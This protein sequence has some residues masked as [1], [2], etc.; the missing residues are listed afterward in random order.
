MMP[1][2]CLMS[3]RRRHWQRSKT[4]QSIDGLDKYSELFLVFTRLFLTVL[5]AVLFGTSIQASEAD[6][7][8]ALQEGAIVLFRHANAPG[9][10]DPPG[11]RLGDCTTQRNLDAVGREQARR[12]G[13]TFRQKRIKIGEVLT[14]QWCRTEET[15]R[16]AF[17][18]TAKGE[19]IFNSF[20]DDRTNGPLQT[21]AATEL[22]SQWKW[23]G[24]LVVV[25]HQVNITALTDVFPASGEGVV[26]RIIN[27]QVRV[28]G[29]IKP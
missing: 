10:G 24:S 4:D 5:L 9:G 14:S 15:A 18:D 17:G 25:T 21:K 29:R 28:V 23:S 13:E 11:L 27:G 3:I 2:F 22:L 26:L 7:W 12:I 1:L 16:L 8:K 19:P 6:A 20:F